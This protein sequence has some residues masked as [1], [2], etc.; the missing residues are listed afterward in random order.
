MSEKGNSSIPKSPPVRARRDSNS[1][2]ALSHRA[3][4]SAGPSD[5]I[6]GRTCVRVRLSD[7]SGLD[8]STQG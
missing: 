7:F 4:V 8:V 3:A 2:L 6:V 5:A 1:S